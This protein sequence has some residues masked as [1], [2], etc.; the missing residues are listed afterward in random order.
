MCEVLLV[1]L[2]RMVRSEA[3]LNVTPGTLDCVSVVFGVLIEERNAVV[4]GAVGVTP[5]LDV[6][7]RTPAISDERSA[8][9][10]PSTDYLRQCVG[11]SIPYGNQK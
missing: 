7:I 3:S 4:H 11:G 8:V 5:S 9:F 2:P 6:P 10:D 1:V